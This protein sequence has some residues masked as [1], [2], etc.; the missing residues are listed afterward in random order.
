M[1]LA[2]DL[3]LFFRNSKTKLGLSL[4]HRGLL[5]TL[6]IRIGS[7]ASTWIKQSTLAKEA[8]IDERN[9]RENMNKIKSTG[10]VLVDYQKS[11]KRKLQYR[12]N[13]LLNN[14]HLLTEEERIKVHLHL[15][16][17]HEHLNVL[18]HKSS[19]KKYRMKSS[20]NLQDTGRN[21]PVDTGRNHPIIPEND[22]LE[23]PLPTAS[24]EVDCAP[25]EK[26]ESNKKHKGK[27]KT[28]LF[29]DD[30]KPT[31]E[32]INLA[33]EH[34]LDINLQ[35]QSLRAWAMGGNKENEIIA[36]SRWGQ[37]FTGWLIRSIEHG[38]GKK[39][40]QVNVKRPTNY[41]NDNVVVP[42]YEDWTG[43]AERNRLERDAKNAK[44]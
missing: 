13:K 40:I 34:G 42:K 16:D 43:V 19:S 15:N 39:N 20:H 28:T 44:I 11:D 2:L 14:Y 23:I 5:F 7:N 29:P 4:T 24:Y 1:S 9:V 8:G 6:A 30:F 36:R 37:T 31:Q 35:I 25:K 32:H 18:K 41:S 12:F 3:G 26:E 21:H 33:N 17:E 10:I 38:G 22:S 27:E